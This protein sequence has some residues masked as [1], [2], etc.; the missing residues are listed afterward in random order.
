MNIYY[1]RVGSDG[2]V[3]EHSIREDMLRARGVD[4]RSVV[5]CSVLACQ[6]PR[7]DQRRQITVVRDADR[8][9]VIHWLTDISYEEILGLISR[10]STGA[11]FSAFVVDQY[12]KAFWIMTR[13]QLNHSLNIYA[14]SLDF[15]DFNDLVSHEDSTVETLKQK[16]LNAICLRDQMVMVML[17]LVQ[18]IRNGAPVPESYQELYGRMLKVMEEQAH[19]E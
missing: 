13:K 16:A 12:Y 19:A 10:L 14:K 5:P 18:D 2:A 6:D 8:V 4:L 7:I 11:A 3:I 15:L 1:A 17:G 9:R